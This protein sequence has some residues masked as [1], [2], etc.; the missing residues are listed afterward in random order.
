MGRST[1]AEGERQIMRKGLVCLIIISL[2]SVGYGSA[3]QIDTIADEYTIGDTF[4]ITGTTN[5][6]AGNE[7]I[8]TFQ[9]VA[10]EPTAKDRPAEFSGISGVARVIQGNGVNTGSFPVDTSGFVTDE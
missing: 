3:L 9:S 6:A 7:L 5:L 4:E 8:I 1:L 10:F 2:V